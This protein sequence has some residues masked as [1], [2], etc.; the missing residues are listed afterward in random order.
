[1]FTHKKAWHAFHSDNWRKDMRKKNRKGLEFFI[2]VKF[3]GRTLNK[4]FKLHPIQISKYQYMK[5][6]NMLDKGIEN[7]IAK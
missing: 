1:M 3:I 4:S 2:I 5:I 7:Y 6:R